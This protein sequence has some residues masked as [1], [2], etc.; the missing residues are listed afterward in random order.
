MNKKDVCPPDCPGRRS[1][2]HAECRRYLKC[3]RE[4]LRRYKKQADAAMIDDVRYQKT[5]ESG[6]R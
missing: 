6:K 1:G 5:R 2:C 4:N 3:R